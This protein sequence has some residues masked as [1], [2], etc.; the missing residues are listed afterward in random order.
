MNN[1]KRGYFVKEKD[2]DFGIPI[3][4][5]T[6]REA[7][8][9]AYSQTELDCDFIDVRVRWRKDASVEDLPIGVI[10]DELLALKRDMFDYLEEY[11]CEICG[12][13]ATLEMWNEKAICRDCR[14]E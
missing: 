8:I 9:I 4:A 13:V 3:V 11:E 10:E 5:A 6:A 7:K 14:G 1:K 2:G 12:K